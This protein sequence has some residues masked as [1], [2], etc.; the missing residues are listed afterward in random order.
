MRADD[1][2]PV[3]AGLQSKILRQARRQ[4]VKA[5]RPAL[6][7]PVLQ[8]ILKLLGSVALSGVHSM[9]WSSQHW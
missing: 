8:H 7:L 5:P 4:R 9:S 6:H 3:L 2:G 1:R